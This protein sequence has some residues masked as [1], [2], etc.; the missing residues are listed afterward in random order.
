MSLARSWMAVSRMRFSSLRTGAAAAISSRL[1]S[2]MDWLVVSGTWAAISA[3]ATPSSP[4]MSDM[5]S[6][7]L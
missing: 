3:A 1:S 5:F 4:R 6:W 2:S 7:L